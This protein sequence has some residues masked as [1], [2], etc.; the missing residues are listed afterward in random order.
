MYQYHRLELSLT[1]IY[2]GISI[3]TI[4]GQRFNIGD[5]NIPFCIQSCSKALNYA[6]N[7]AELGPEKVHQHLG[8]EPSGVGFNQISVSQVIR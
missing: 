2:S 3:C 4:D 1:F 5:T 7:V 6:I 8:K